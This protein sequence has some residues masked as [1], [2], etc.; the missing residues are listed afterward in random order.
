MANYGYI[1][2]D[3]KIQPSELRLAL[4]WAV[5]KWFRGRMQVEDT[6]LS[7]GG[8]LWWVFIPYSA[9][10]EA[11]ALKFGLAPN[12]DFGFSVALQGKGKTIAFRHPLNGF[13]HWAQGCI[14]EM[15]SEHFD[16]GITYD[17]SGETTKV[18]PKQYRARRR[19]GTYLARN[20]TK[21]LSDGDKTWL[22]RFKSTTP[23]GWW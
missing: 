9:P 16:R 3:R 19:Y 6:Q 1:Y 15:L 22:D 20:F 14:E 4:R 17:A 11:D 21:P 5:A 2:L 18:G 7:D 10:P 23:E 13:E 12:Q 8:P